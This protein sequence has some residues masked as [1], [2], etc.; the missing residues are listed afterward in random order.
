MEKK[1]P[2]PRTPDSSDDEGTVILSP[3]PKRPKRDEYDSD[4]SSVTMLL[5]SEDE[6]DD[7]IENIETNNYLQMQS[8]N[9]QERA[10]EIC[11]YINSERERIL[12]RFNYVN[13]EPYDPEMYLPAIVAGLEQVYLYF[14]SIANGTRIVK[15]SDSDEVNRAIQLVNQRLLEYER[16]VME[17]SKEQAIEENWKKYGYGHPTQR[18]ITTRTQLAKRLRLKL[19]A[20]QIKF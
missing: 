10:K 8:K 20:L 4:D 19:S 18:K 7:N 2:R 13:Q 16:R 1:R 17:I 9:I 11:M 15:D 3:S 14:K 5:S 12:K 6:D